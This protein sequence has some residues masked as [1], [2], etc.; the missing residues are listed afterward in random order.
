MLPRRLPAHLVENARRLRHEATDAD[1][2]LWRMLRN[3]QF[4]GYK[5][6][7]QVPVGHYILDFL[8]IEAR[9]AVEL[10]G[11]QHAQMEREL[12]DQRRSAGLEERGIRIV[13]FWNDEVLRDPEGTAER[14]WVALPHDEPDPASAEG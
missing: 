13:R 3:R 9:L 2:L 11:G 14:L 8:C 1:G 7:R 12:A 5:F 10:D 6:R 4:G